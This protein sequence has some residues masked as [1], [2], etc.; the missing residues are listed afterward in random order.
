MDKETIRKAEDNALDITK[1]T[2][3]K[4]WVKIVVAAIIGAIAA[5]LTMLQ[6]SCASSVKQTLPDGTVKERTFVLDG[7]SAARLIELYGIPQVPAVNPTK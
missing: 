1:K 7:Q 3:W 2:N 5:V 4:N 6:T